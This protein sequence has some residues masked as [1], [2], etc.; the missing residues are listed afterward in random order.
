MSPPIRDGSGSSIGSIRLGDG[1]E[2][3]EVRTGAG[4]VLFS[5][6]PDSAIHQ[7]KIDESSG[8]TINDNIATNNGSINGAAW[9][10]GTW[11]G[12]YALDF[13]GS[14]D[15]VAL[16]SSISEFD[17]NNEKFSF[18]V[19]VELDD[20]SNEQMIFQNVI[21]SNNR[22][23][24]QVNSNG[25]WSCG[26]YDGSWKS[27][28]EKTGGVSSNKVRLGVGADGSSANLELYL[29]GTRVDDNSPGSSPVTAGT[30]TLFASEGANKYLNGRLDNALA[31]DSLL[32]SDA[33]VDDYNRQPWS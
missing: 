15:E 16:D 33:F 6:I 7:W 31:F 19:T 1:S 5:A 9:T 20:T 24:V 10:N 13:D 29:N 4:D 3:S 25:N 14:N 28:R 21:S 32:S 27:T 8:T 2:I 17:V 18:A 30:S 11:V 26:M 12:S 23:S 22:L